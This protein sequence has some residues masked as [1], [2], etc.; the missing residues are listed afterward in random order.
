MPS[1]AAFPAN[2]VDTLVG[3]KT[4]TPTGLWTLADV[5]TIEKNA[6]ADTS[7]NGAIGVFTDNWVPLDWEIGAG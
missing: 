6:L 1:D 3:V 2:I 5:K 4:P 7:A